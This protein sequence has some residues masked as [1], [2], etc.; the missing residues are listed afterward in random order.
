MFGTNSTTVNPG[1][2]CLA[3]GNV[4]NGTSCL[5]TGFPGSNAHLVFGPVP[6]PPGSTMTI[7]HLSA[8]EQASTTGV[9]IT[10]LD[11]GTPTALTCTVATGSACNDDGDTVT[12]PAGDFLEVSATGGGGWL[13]TFELG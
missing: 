13:V 10:V 9:T 6:G 2:L 8:S 11:N 12:I 5:T 7:S 4:A 3:Y 1:P